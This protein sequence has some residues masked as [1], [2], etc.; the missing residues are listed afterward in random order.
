MGVRNEITFGIRL[1]PS[2]RLR[3]AQGMVQLSALI[4]VTIGIGHF[5][6][7]A[8]PIPIFVSINPQKYFVQQIATNRV[9]VQVMVP[10]GASPAT[11]EPRPRQV[12]NLTKT[13]IYFAVG[14]PFENAWLHKIEA[15]NP[16]MTIVH[17]DEGIDK[18]PM[19]SHHFDGEAH[20]DAETHGHSGLD[21]HI[22]LSPPLV[23][24]QS[25]TIL[26]ALQK[27][28]PSH[29]AAYQ[30]NYEQFVAKI[31]RLDNDLKR[32]F[33]DKQGL[34][35]M[36]FH[37]SWGYFAKAYGLRQVAVEIEGKNP[38]PAQLKTLIEY[39]RDKDIRV[40]FVQ[41]QFSTKSARLVAKEIGGQVVFADPLATDW[42]ANLRGI[43]QKFKAAL[44]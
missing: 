33:K 35:F 42:L 9:N 18:I 19:A 36:V 5:A 4:F 11:Y 31:D 28:D 8:S 41:P 13:K 7:A 44:K 22:W 20:L 3:V 17:T 39:A 2:R 6:R 21:P 38:K 32:L 12:A 34:Q 1:K 24:I 27:M 37:P 26:Q 16:D 23:K 25:R 29:Q 30:G 43:A 14:V 10:A 15:A 40:I